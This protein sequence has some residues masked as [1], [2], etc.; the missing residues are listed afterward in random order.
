MTGLDLLR[1]LSS[2]RSVVEDETLIRLL[3]SLNGELCSRILR[4][5]VA[6]RLLHVL[7]AEGETLR[8]AESLATEALLS[9]KSIPP[10]PLQLM[11]SFG[12]LGSAQALES[13]LDPRSTGIEGSL[14]RFLAQPNLIRD[15]TLRNSALQ[16]LEP[17]GLTGIAHVPLLVAR[18]PAPQQVRPSYVIHSTIALAPGRQ[19]NEVH[20]PDAHP[21]VVRALHRLLEL[22]TEDL[23]ARFTWTLDRLAAVVLEADS[24]IDSFGL[25]VYVACARLKRGEFVHPAVA[26]TGC[27]RGAVL[28]CPAMLQQK[29]QAAITAGIRLLL[30]PDGTELQSLS[31]DSTWPVL[32]QPLPT[33]PARALALVSSHLNDEFP[34]LG[35]VGSFRPSVHDSRLRM[36]LG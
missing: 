28:E 22:V 29:V 3:C 14:K 6:L 21:V 25:P 23:G 11:T 35:R 12:S 16:R 4:P 31:R 13:R 34:V 10:L 17:E 9:G 18:D 26:F 27:R 30:V 1:L 8:I 15:G 5:E 7:P 32:V 19:R 36:W 2:S 20:A 24:P 33:S